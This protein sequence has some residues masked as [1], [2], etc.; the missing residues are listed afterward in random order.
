M[1]T[2]ISLVIAACLTQTSINRYIIYVSRLGLTRNSWAIQDR[3]RPVALSLVSL[4]PWEKSLPFVLD[5]GLRVFLKYSSDSNLYQL[6]NFLSACLLILHWFLVMRPSASVLMKILPCSV[7]LSPL[8][9]IRALDPILSDFSFCSK[10]M[11]PIYFVI[12]DRR[13]LLTLL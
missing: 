13:E 6:I 11:T 1:K 7:L 3:K 8:W 4:S 12:M 5:P 9:V 2:H 10:W